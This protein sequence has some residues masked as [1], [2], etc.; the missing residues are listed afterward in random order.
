MSMQILNNYWAALVIGALLLYLTL[1]FLL[2][3]VRKARALGSH[4][5]SALAAI[6]E[7]TSDGPGGITDL[8]QIAERAMTS[9]RLAYLWGEYVKTLH[10][11]KD[12]DG[13]GQLHVVR[14]RATC[15]AGTF[16][17]QEAV[18]D[19]PL[20]VE[21]YKHLPSILTG[22]G[23][24]GTFS[25]LI[26]GLLHFD[27]SSDPS[28]AEAGLR[29]LLSA[30]GH[31][32]IVSGTAIAL[33]MLF[34]AIDKRLISSRYTQVEKLQQAIDKLF[35]TGAEEEYLERI[36]RAA[37]TSATQALQIK[38]SLV[39][40]LKQV[41][42]EITNLQ[43]E[44]S[45]RHSTM[46][47]TEVGRVISDSLGAPIERISHAVERVGA[48][49]GDAVNRLLVDVLASFTTQV[50]DMFGGQMFGL[51]ELLQKS[52]T[53][54]E[55]TA[56]KF[57][58]LASNMEIAGKT[59]ADAM[60]E[61]LLAAVNAM[62]ARQQ[63]LNHQ[64]GEFVEQIR[65]IVLNSQT[66]SGAKIQ[67]L[68]AQMGDQVLSVAAQLRSQVDATTSAQTEQ[69]DR[70]TRET[71]LAINSMSEQVEQLIAQSLEVS[72]ALQSSVQAL[73]SATSDSILKMN[74]GAEMLYIA[75]S[76]FAKA[77]QGVTEVIKLTAPTTEKINAAAQ[78]LLSAS[79]VTQQVTSEYGKSRDSFSLIVSELR[80]TI[81]AAKREASV[82][83]DLVAAIR[84]ASEQL[85][86]AEKQ[87]ESYLAGVTE[88]LAK[89]HESFAENVE[90]T[91]RTGNAQFHKE[92]S[93][94]MSL[95]SGGIQDLGDLLESVPSRSN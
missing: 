94:A 57:E 20:R 35:S 7:I 63:M 74:S 79:N 64:M 73:S 1:D 54:M 29:D 34:T 37:E 71:G 53:A 82:T 75:S 60:S 40:D 80:T 66:E 55:S 15:L 85:Q 27:V 28:L 46:I 9:G 51:S 56:V 92:L 21:Y 70:M 78:A 13:S 52:A 10:P 39:A 43:V 45:A 84:S 76:D 88:V 5:E 30:V 93:E 91:L 36:V 90:R 22:I 12:H 16:F 24:I 81:E 59:A 19:T 41:L 65:T 77:G 87:A 49:Q 38:D 11:Q 48:S 14:W 31:A 2:K 62:E 6:S 86:I 69:T 61:R 47:S 83:I 50:R 44:A 95:L 32:F 89:A 4:L 3:F 42:S 26:L 58:A 72:T 25:G 33:A 67:E 18:V 17:T 68:L 23:I 8:N